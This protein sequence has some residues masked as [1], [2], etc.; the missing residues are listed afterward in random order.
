MAPPT[1]EDG[2]KLKPTYL[3][4]F[5]WS[6]AFWSP[7]NGSKTMNVLAMKGPGGTQGVAQLWVIGKLE[8][9]TLVVNQYPSYTVKLCL[10]NNERT[11]F[12]MMLKKW[13]NLGKDWDSSSIESVVN[14][15]T[16]LEKVQELIDLI[17][18]DKEI[19]DVVQA[20]H[21]Q[22]TF[23]FT[24]DVR[25]SADVNGDSPDSG[26]DVD[27][28]K[29]GAKVAVEFQLIFQNFKASKKIDAVKAYSF[30]LLGVYLI[31]EP[32]RST[33]SNPEKRRRGEDEWMVTPPRTKKT[34]TSMNSL[35]S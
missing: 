24:Y 20:I 17:T 32:N 27:D 23:P 25:K 22:D 29:A 12:R 9:T 31:D 10:T 30:R 8:Y 34:I 26:H 13:G 21:F 5:D 14:F 18:T 16:R 33:I 2:M 6:K 35:E 1:W 15:S 3:A 11:T 19:R 7:L 4:N 28:F